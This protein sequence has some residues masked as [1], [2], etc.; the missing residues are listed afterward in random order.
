[1]PTILRSPQPLFNVAS[2]C[3]VSTL[4]DEEFQTIRE[5]IY[6]EAGISM[7]DAKRALVCSRLAKRLRHL[8]LHSH[9]E[10]LDYLATQDPAGVERQL[11]INCLTTNK[12]DF[13][14]EPHHFE[15]LRQVIFPEVKRRAA[16]GRPRRLRIWSAG[17][18]MG[19]E[20]HTI[21]MTILE[22]FGSLHGWD[23]RILASDIN[24]DVLRTAEQ[25][26]YPL[27]RIA[28]MEEELKCRYF[29]RGTGRW[30]GFCQVRPEVRRLVTF[31]RI[32]FMDNP[33]PIHTRFDVIFCRNVIIYF[34]AQTQ[35]QLLP[36]F[37]E[38][39]AEDG[40]LILGHS[41]N[42]HWLSRLFVSCGNTVY[43]R[44]AGANLPVAESPLPLSRLR[45]TNAALQ[46]SGEAGRTVGRLPRH[47]IIAGEYFASREPVEICTILG[48]C[49]AACLFD[50]VTRIGGMT[51]FMLPYHATDLTVSA[52]YGIHAMELLINEIMKMG[53]DRRRFQAKVFGGA[54]MFRCQGMTMDVGKRN[55]KFI[56]EFLAAENI[57]IV[58][59]RLG[60]E[61]PLR[62]HFSSD[63]GKALVK[64]LENRI[65]VIE[66]E[67][68]YSQTAAALLEKPF[69][70]NVTLF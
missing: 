61:N 65:G 12:T 24:T 66:R 69:N 7:S 62:V 44:R 38:H 49:V 50:P 10:Y 6:R 47:E 21:A 34:N 51:H 13:F 52:R 29:L 11:M 19:D 9:G 23:V 22:H 5:L 8:N 2:V 1:M 36:R 37:A 26:I 17:C 67:T 28:F 18:S 27:E 54:N 32:N 16:Q 4:T 15:F 30:D 43:Q 25:G 48:S 59:E 68:R 53:G 39:L 57:P 33:W 42:L 55:A 63:T 64:V 60:G 35:Q 3:N 41:E 45:Q 31:R 70:E 20:P 56:R 58:A 14:R 40:H 46:Q